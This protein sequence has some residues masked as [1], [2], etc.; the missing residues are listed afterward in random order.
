MKGEGDGIV[1]IPPLMAKRGGKHILLSSLTEEAILE[2][3]ELV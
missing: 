3:I 2:G 1:P